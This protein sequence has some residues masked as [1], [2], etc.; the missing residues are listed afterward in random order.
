[1]LCQ[2]VEL[3]P[4]IIILTYLFTYFVALQF[5][6]NSE[7]LTYSMW[8]FMTTNFYRVGSSAPR[9]TPNM[10]DQGICLSL[11]PPW[12][13]VWYGRHSFRVHWC[14]QAPSQ[15]LF[16]NSHKWFKLHCCEVVGDIC[17]ELHTVLRSVCSVWPVS[18]PSVIIAAVNRRLARV[19]SAEVSNKVRGLGGSVGGSF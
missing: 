19:R 3:V 9:P 5:L 10:E 13:P 15:L 4:L 11:T 6:Y 12:K 2:C 1:M 17:C 14:T 7:R 16:L 8:G 18:R